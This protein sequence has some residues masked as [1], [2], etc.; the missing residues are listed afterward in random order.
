MTI[1]AG[2]TMAHS[3]VPPTPGPLF[4]ADQLGVELGLMIVMG[5]FVGT[6]ACATGYVYAK[7]INGESKWHVPLRDSADS[8]LPSTTKLPPRADHASCSS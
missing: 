2:A 1:V 8:P 5:L 4:V 3:L 7:W 6:V